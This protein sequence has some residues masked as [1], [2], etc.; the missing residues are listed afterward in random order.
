LLGYQGGRGSGDD[1]P[2]GNYLRF[3]DHNKSF[4]GTLAYNPLRLTVSLDGWPEPAV[5]GQLV[6][7]NYYAVLDVNA[8]LGRTILADDDLVPDGHPV[9]VISDNYWRRRFA[10]DPSVV[11]RT[12]DLSGTPFTII[13]VTPP[14]FFG[15]EV[16]TVADISVPTMMQRQAMPGITED[17]VRYR[18][19]GRLKPGV[20][21]EQARADLSLLYQQ[22]LRDL[23]ARFGDAIRSKGAQQLLERK[24]TLTPGS[25]GL[26]V[27][28]RQ[29]SQ[30]LFILMTI[31]GLV[32]L[33]ACA[34]VA[35][36]LLARA[37]ARR[38][39]IG[40]RLALGASRARLVRQLLTESLLLAGLGGCLGLGF[41]YWGAK[42][43]VPLLPQGEMPIRLD[44]SPDARLLV[45]SLGLS[46][47]TGVLFGLTPAFRAT[48]VDLNTELKDEA[49]RLGARGA[50]LTMGKLFVCDARN[51]A[52][53]WA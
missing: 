45:F 32:L 24:L 52:S 43:L 41:A 40:I 14:E 18:V 27:L 19:M 46:L 30:P 48:R 37:T 11:G 28:R 7:G 31:V 53:G 42:L 20:T 47:L 5:S 21:I 6:T 29:F 39:E 38:K 12:I 10:R 16:G 50:R 34:N 33:I 23:S 36:L 8:S 44:L 25:Q 1:F 4:S 26:S 3:R 35:G 9:C 22:I 17:Q 2:Y 51:A 49:Q 13:G 15:L